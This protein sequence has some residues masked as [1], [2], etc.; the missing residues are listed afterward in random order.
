M[1]SEVNLTSIA[2][3]KVLLDFTMKE[4]LVSRFLHAQTMLVSR[5]SGVR[6]CKW[7]ME[8]YPSQ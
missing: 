3:I 5:F 2:L 1:S 4:D 8:L 7:T 6:T